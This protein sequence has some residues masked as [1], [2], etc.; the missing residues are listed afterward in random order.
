MKEEELGQKYFLHKA[1]DKEDN[2]FR[3]MPTM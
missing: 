2:F 1:K 3:M